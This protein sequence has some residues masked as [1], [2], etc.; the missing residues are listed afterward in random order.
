MTAVLD[1]GFVKSSMADFRGVLEP[2]ARV[3]MGALQAVIRGRFL[4]GSLRRGANVRVHT[5]STNRDRS[6]CSSPNVQYRQPQTVESNNL[7]VRTQ[8]ETVN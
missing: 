4:M 8:P 7:T 5:A 3:D 1:R 6:C 2:I